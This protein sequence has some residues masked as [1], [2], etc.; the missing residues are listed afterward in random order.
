[1][2]RRRLLEGLGKLR[3]RMVVTLVRHR[4][5]GG[6][7]AFFFPLKE[8]QAW[9][10]HDDEPTGKALR[11]DIGLKSLR[12]YWIGVGCLLLKSVRTF[13]RRFLDKFF[14]YCHHHDLTILF[15]YIYI[16]ISP[17]L[18]SSLSLKSVDLFHIV[19]PT[20]RPG[21]SVN[22][23]VTAQRRWINTYPLRFSPYCRKCIS[24]K[25]SVSPLSHIICLRSLYSAFSP[26]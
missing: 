7:R 12:R 2:P 17:L 9:R 21:F 13:S 22:F 6:T 23:V 20:L 10:I 14:V 8:A 18:S 5:R 24:I 26:W 15:I 16:Y 1:M 19:W 11:L 25:L 3:D 4:E